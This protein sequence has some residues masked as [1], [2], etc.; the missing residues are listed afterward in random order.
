MSDEIQL[1]SDGNGLAVIGPQSA[2][3]LFLTSRELESTEMST[4]RLSSIF[5]GIS[6]AGQAGATIAENS[7]RWVQISEKSARQIKQFGLM[8]SRTTGL[9]L[10]TVTSPETGRIKALV[11]FTKGPQELGALVGNPAALGGLAGM[12]SQ[13]AM[14][15]KMDEITDYLAVIDEKVD[16]ILR[17][18]KDA[19]LAEMI[20]AGLMIDE[21]LTVRSAHGTTDELTWNKVQQLPGTISVTQAYALRQID[22]L[23]SKVEARAK[24]GDLAKNVADVDARVREWLA[25]LARCFQLLDSIAVL[26]IDRAFELNP[27]TVDTHR[28]G[29][30]AARTRRLETIGVATGL[31][32]TRIEAAAK[33][34][35][36]KVLLHPTTARTIVGSS[37]SVHEKVSAFH[38]TVGITVEQEQVRARRWAEAAGELRDK[39]LETGAESLESAR[40][41][42]TETLDRAKTAAVETRGRALEATEKVSL[43]IA[44]RAAQKRTAGEPET[45][46]AEIEAN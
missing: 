2:I 32:L 39:L 34:A 37:N 20:G 28:Q 10:G 33:T 31:L 44:E 43:S 18:Q 25:V 42:S 4:S 19:A 23:A 36:G 17:A 29:L 6:G 24:L 38:T 5:G 41:F 13:Y 8:K 46:P 15:Q 21:A 26:E 22:A 40:S 30:E 12:M 11:E 1:I 3:E 16:D 45:G 7:G 14:Q 9:S 35:N 27:S